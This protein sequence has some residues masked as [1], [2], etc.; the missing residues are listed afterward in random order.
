MRGVVERVKERM[1]VEKNVIREEK[2]G[3]KKS[4]EG[5]EWNEE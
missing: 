3:K 5:F 4:R 2:R 1:S